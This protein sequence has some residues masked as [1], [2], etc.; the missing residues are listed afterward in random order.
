MGDYNTAVLIV[1]FLPEGITRENSF[2][3]IIAC[4]LI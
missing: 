2:F 1:V 3:T 4:N